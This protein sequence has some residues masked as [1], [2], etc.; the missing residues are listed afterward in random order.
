MWRSRKARR[1]QTL[2]RAQR[3]AR[4]RHGRRVLVAA[5]ATL[6]LSL[7][8]S[9]CAGS[10]GQRTSASQTPS[11]PTARLLDHALAGGA[12]NVKPQKGI[13][14]RVRGG[15][16]V[17][18]SVKTSGDSVTG[19]L[20]C[21]AT[22]L[23]QP[24]GPRYRHAATRS[25][26]Q[27]RDAAGRTVTVTSTLRTLNP[28][29][30]FSA[31]IFQGQGLTYGVGMPIILQ[32]SK[33]I[34]DKKA[35]EQSLRLWASRR[36]VGAWYWDGSST[37]YFRPRTYWP[38]HT[39]V[40]FVGHLDGVEG[41]PG[42][43]GAHTLRQSFD[44]GRSLIAVANTRAHHVRIYKDRHLWANWPISTGRPGDDTPNG[45]YLT[46][47]KQ[48]PAH[49]KGPGYDIQVPWSVRFTWSGDYL[50]DASWSVG[51]QGFTNVSHGCVN[52]SPEHA[53][54]YYELAVPGD[55][56]TVTG[57]PKAGTWDDGWTVWFL[58]WRKLLRG[59]AL[60]E[61][62]RVGPNGSTFVDPA[63]LRPSRAKP[64]LSA[65]RSRNAAPA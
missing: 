9:A 60:H 23:A 20:D 54:T 44:I 61:A 56:V 19:I 52:L 7:I 35:V 28:R 53:Q 59:S 10:A 5:A 22:T 11:V 47:E 15:T 42:V 62:V 29:Q 27:R 31:Q 48:N 12:R 37:L 30:T 14:V 17:T 43:Y 39:K 3:F 41:S 51:E 13:M 63:S 55:P 16:L 57:S 6:C 49:M 25:A 21:A 4:G 34:T 36:V 1:T 65:P 64:P 46:I 2:W 50:H 45:T 32:F 33:P 26:P 40:R 38:Q 58:S 8:G 18:V 24:L